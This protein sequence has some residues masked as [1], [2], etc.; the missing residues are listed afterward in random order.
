MNEACSFGQEGNTK[1]RSLII[2]VYLLQVSIR[3]VDFQTWPILPMDDFAPATRCRNRRKR[4][5]CRRC[6]CVEKS[7]DNKSLKL[8]MLGALLNQATFAA[9]GFWRS[10]KMYKA[11]QLL[12]VSCMTLSFLLFTSLVGRALHTIPSRLIMKHDDAR[13]DVFCNLSI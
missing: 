7:F 6:T 13:K 12:L 3:I 11:I 9:P 8:L 4:L 10:W 5:Q 2:H 1:A